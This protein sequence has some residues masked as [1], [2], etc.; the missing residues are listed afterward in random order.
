MMYFLIV[1][2]TVLMLAGILFLY[3]KFSDLK[4]DN[5]ENLLMQNMQ[6]TMFDQLNAMSKQMSDR[7]REMNESQSRSHKSVGER[8]DTAAKVVNT[9][10]SRLAQLEESNKRIHDIGKDIAGLQEI[11]RAPKLRGNLGE[12]FLGDL[13][14]QIFPKEHFTMQYA[15]K[16]GEK[17]DAVIHLRDSLMVPVDA[18]FPLENFRKML[19]ADKEKAERESAAFRKVFVNDVKKHIDDIAKKYI[20]PD[21]GTFDFA[22]MYIPAEN[23]YYETIVKDME[24]KSIS[25]YALT[26]KVIPVSPNSFYIYL[27]AILMG[28]RGLQIEKSAK[29]IFTNL[30]RLRTDFSKFGDDFGLVGKHLGHAQGSYENSQKRLMKFENKLESVESISTPEKPPMI[31][32]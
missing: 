1:F 6:K 9:V 12:L 2:S 30:A 8:L 25:Q 31:E 14:S 11:L 16:S 20:V 23:V 3:K 19:G 18:K 26:K 13:L 27:Q 32:D 7:L 15:F 17:V 22:L 10:N 24:D 28:L 5:S 4:P 29:E 21:E